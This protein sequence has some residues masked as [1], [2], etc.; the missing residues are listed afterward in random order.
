MW[1]TEQ[2]R[3]ELIKQDMSENTINSYLG[4][5]RDFSC[6]MKKAIGEDIVP[7]DITEID[8][9]EYRSCL[10]NE[11]K[12]S[13]A[14]INNKL[15][16]LVRYCGFLKNAGILGSNSASGISKIKVQ[17]R[18]VSPATLPRNDLYRLRRV[19]HKEGNLR[20][21]LIFEFLYNTGIRVSE[22]CS[23]EL[24]D[25][26]V[27]ERKGTL[28]IRK[29]KGTK[30]RAVPLNSDARSALSAYLD[31]MSL[32]SGEKLL[33]GQRGPLGRGAVYRVIKKYADLAGLSDVSPHTLRHQFCRNLLDSGVDIVTVANLAGHSDIN[34]TVIYTQPTEE[35][36][37]QALEKL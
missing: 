5:V 3:D 13:P 17:D 18:Q 15:S 29:G 16:A 10:L 28:V 27:S 8:I 11:K 26:E 36:K 32:L 25:I 30:Y 35:E 34:T 20:D 1:Y 22:F 33:Q 12:Q 19:F 31:T 37:A 23:I 14:T 9:K 21:I 2:F 7:D 4:T 24:D 6:F